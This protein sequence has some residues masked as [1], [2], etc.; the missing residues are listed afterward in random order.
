MS[1]LKRAHGFATGQAD[2][3]NGIREE[4]GGYPDRVTHR[5]SHEL[6]RST[7]SCVRLIVYL[8]L[9]SYKAPMVKPVLYHSSYCANSKRLLENIREHF[10]VNTITFLD[11]S[12]QRGNHRGLQN[13]HTVGRRS[14]TR[15]NIRRRPTIRP[16]QA[17]RPGRKHNFWQQVE[18][19]TGWTWP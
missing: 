14:Y 1:P 12:T 11:V 6:R 17:P 8:I 13:P 7:S 19:R 16:V 18:P 4:V 10:D 2:A 9:K 15:T 5:H 3:Q